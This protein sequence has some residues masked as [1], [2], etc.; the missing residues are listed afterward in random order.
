MSKSAGF[1]AL[2]AYASLLNSEAIVDMI[3]EGL[4][5]VKTEMLLAHSEQECIQ[6]LDSHLGMVAFLITIKSS[7]KDLSSLLNDVDKV[8][9]IMKMMN[10]NKG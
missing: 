1:G 3:E 7:G 9:S 10:P 5:K 6:I 4:K 8:D 2:I